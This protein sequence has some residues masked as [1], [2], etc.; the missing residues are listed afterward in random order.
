MSAEG[1]SIKSVLEQSANPSTEYARWKNE[2]QYAC[3]ELG[4]W[5]KKGIKALKRYSDDRTA[6]E[7]D[8]KRYNLFASNV[9]VLSASLYSTPPKVCVTRKFD[10]FDDDI[11]RVA[12]IILE[13]CLQQDLDES[14]SPLS[15]VFAQAVQDRLVPGMGTAWLRVEV[16]EETVV[17]PVS[18]QPVSIVNGQEVI[19]DHV[20]WQDLL[21]S[22]C[23]TWDERRW[24]A[25]RVYMQYD[26]GVKR[27]GDKFKNVPMSARPKREDENGDVVPENKLIQEAAIYEIWDRVDKKV[28]WISTDYAE[29]LDKKDDFLKIDNFEPTPQPFFALV[30]TSTCIP[31]PDYI[32]WID[33]YSELDT[34]NQRISMLVKALRVAGVYDKAQEGVKSLMLEGTDNKLIPVDNWAMFAE[35][36]GLK[37]TIDWLPIDV[38]VEVQDKLRAAREDIKQQLYELTG[39]SDVVRG[40]SNPHETLGAQ[41]MKA[42]FASSRIQVLQTQLEAWVTQLLK[43]KAE[44]MVRHFPAEALIQMS[45][46]L[47]T[48]DAALAPQAVAAL[49]QES[50]F[51][52]RIGVEPFSMAQI[53]YAQEKEDRI[54]FLT[55]IGGFLEKAVV[56][57]QQMPDLIPLM[58]T[59]IK[60]AV[61]GYR[62]SATIEGAIDQTLNGIM[63]K[64]KKEQ[65][66]PTP[67]P[68][69][70]E[71]IKGQIEFAKLDQEKQRMEMESGVNQAEVNFKAEEIKLK[72]QEINNKQ[73]SEQQ[74]L[75]FELQKID[76]EMQFER[77]KHEMEM[78]KLTLEMEIM[79]EKADS[80][81]QIALIGA[82]TSIQTAEEQSRG[83]AID[84]A[85]KMVE[86]KNKENDNEMGS[87]KS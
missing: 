81:M 67:K 52:Y 36:G 11:A 5:H 70:A 12:A 3:K 74:K 49:K 32:R 59:M 80:E 27:F 9:D 78:A 60:F 75:A 77:E 35:K 82:Q 87:E 33:Q 85:S 40:S 65:A 55:T 1:Q 16:D 21:W 45:N 38:I 41:K 61:S 8:A 72:E 64:A 76:Q 14:T 10:D 68:P 58:V 71:E 24:V 79:R 20:H 42:D 2:I 56:A 7:G 43:I 57:G 25:R 23:R 66:N 62:V 34:V 30:T 26:A 83:N 28:I 31:I 54:E 39:I 47:N 6:W 53:D 50:F 15:R 84:M 73:Q 29:I 48:V 18:N 86:L 17:D 4:P 37:G 63:E 46:I 19:A 22:P 44:I 51:E 13:R 69:S